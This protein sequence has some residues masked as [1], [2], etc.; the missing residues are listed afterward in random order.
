MARRIEVFFKARYPSPR[1]LPPTGRGKKR[2]AGGCLRPAD[3][4]GRKRDPAGLGDRRVVAQYL[5]DGVARQ[6]RPGAQLRQL[7]GVPQEGENAVAD[8][9]GGGEIAGDQQQVAGDNNLH[10][11]QAVAGFLG[12]NE[13][14]HEVGSPLPAPLVHHAQQVVAEPLFGVG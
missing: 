11:G 14:A 1:F 6:L 8:Q 5:L 10:L 2:L 4:D 9:V 3:F 13:R 12:R 7:V